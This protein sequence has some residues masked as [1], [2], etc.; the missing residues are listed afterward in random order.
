MTEEKS[1]CNC[2][3]SITGSA[4]G[5]TS[6][7]GK[8][9]KQCD[10]HWNKSSDRVLQYWNVQKKITY[11]ILMRLGSNETLVVTLIFYVSHVCRRS[12]LKFFFYCCTLFSTSYLFI[13]TLYRSIMIQ[14]AFIRPTFSIQTLKQKPPAWIVLH[15][16]IQ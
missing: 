8:C 15:Q 2:T 1:I 12:F 13:K 14:C 6:T 5:T 4:T 3:K 10:T 11:L 16:S 9:K 7:N